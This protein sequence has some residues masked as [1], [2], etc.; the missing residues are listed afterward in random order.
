M[1]N[2]N[3]PRNRRSAR[4]ELTERVE[5]LAQEILDHLASNPL[6]RS[7]PA[8]G[9]SSQRARVARG[10]RSVSFSNICACPGPNCTSRPPASH[11][12]AYSELNPQAHTFTPAARETSRNTAR[13]SRPNR[14]AP[15][16]LCR[17]RLTA[18]TH[19]S[20]FQ[21]TEV[22]DTVAATSV[23]WPPSAFAT[24]ENQTPEKRSDSFSP[25]SPPASHHL[26]QGLLHHLPLLFH[27]VQA[28]FSNLITVTSAPEEPLI[29]ALESSL[30]VTLITPLPELRSPTCQT[31]HLFCFRYCVCDTHYSRE[32]ESTGRASYT[33]SIPVLAK[34]PKA[35][36]S[37]V[38]PHWKCL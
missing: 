11:P 19:R 33:T 23:L 12:P 34:R 5:G 18:H 38:K 22:V 16:N 3:S 8:R 25:A 9:R 6:P 20:G 2:R 28:L 24:E 31:F 27:V 4:Q 21:E 17:P 13:R 7:A 14:A 29:L 10:G 26:L 1:E 36:V 30:P 35:T 32:R 37:V 15:S